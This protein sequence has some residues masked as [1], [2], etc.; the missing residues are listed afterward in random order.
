MF[1]GKMT[2]TEKRAVIS[3]SSIMGLRMI[4]LFMVLPVF[5]LYASKLQGATP[6][7]IGLSLGIYG[8][9]QAF[10]QI[11]FGTL[12]DRYGRKPLILF[13]LL[14]FV[15]GS[16]IAAISHSITLMI[17]GRALQGT[18]AVGSTTLAMFADLTREEQRTKSMAIAGISIGFS[19]SLAMLIGPL[20]TMW[21]PINNLFYLAMLFSLLAIFILY[22]TVPT[23]NRLRWHRDTQPEFKSFLKLVTHLELAKL[24]IGIFILHAIFTASFVI[25]P[26]SIAHFTPI[27]S[28]HQWL[29]YLPT[30]LIA[31]IITLFI[32]GMAEKKQQLK[33]FFVS[34]II[35]LIMSEFCFAFANTNLF[36]I[37]IGLCLFFTGFSVLEAFL[38]SLISR[39]APIEKKGSALGIYSSAQFLGI[40]VGGLLGGWLYG[41]F[42][43]SGVYA[44][45]ILLSFF[46]LALA[47]LMRPLSH[48]ITEVWRFTKQTHWDTV[49]EKLHV[50]PGILEVTF[51]VEDGIAYLKM[52]R[53]T[54]K[55]P[56]FIH[57][58]KYTI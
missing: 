25:I 20:L 7:L 8:L 38:P 6:L 54:V 36:L 22:T 40:F 46:W 21:L 57:L 51:I 15:A 30:L 9:T 45:C 4:G 49:A 24:N 16:Y 1:S 31:F 32:I 42:S 58:K 23:P 26:I 55:H 41:K 34:S 52:E 11:P 39:I 47:L 14:L 13:G 50:I 29:L 19:F 35:L 18:G 2:S 17:L 48:S 33:P 37:V 44:F 56:D 27:S 53:G 43:F 3:L 12:S 10:F 28:H 5:S